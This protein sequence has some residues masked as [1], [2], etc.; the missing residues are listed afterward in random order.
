MILLE[1]LAGSLGHSLTHCNS[2]GEYKWVRIFMFARKK[3]YLDTIHE[4]D[5]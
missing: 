3:L 2:K 4:W 5:N 1:T